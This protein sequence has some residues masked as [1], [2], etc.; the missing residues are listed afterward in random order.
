MLKGVRSDV[1]IDMSC[2]FRGFQRK[3]QDV[4]GYLVALFV[5]LPG[6]ILILALLSHTSLS[7]V[8][9]LLTIYYLVAI[10]AVIAKSA[11]WLDRHL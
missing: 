2:S 4:L 8:G 6:V 10:F 5:F 3:S 11:G 7:I 1:S 9:G